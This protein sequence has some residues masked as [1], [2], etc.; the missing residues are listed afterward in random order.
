MKKFIVNTLAVGLAGL[1]LSPLVN[2]ASITDTSSDLAKVGYSFG[3]MMGEGNKDTVNDLD[4][5][6][7]YQGFKDSY[8]NKQPTLTAEQMQK[9]LVAYGKRREAEY[10]KQ[11]QAL[12]RKNLEQ[13][14]VF[15]AKNAKKAGVI[16]TKSGLQYEVL[17]QGTGKMPTAND[18]V[19]VNYEGHL[20]DGTI[21]DSSIKRGEPV[22]FPLKQVIKGWREGLPLMREGAKYRFFVPAKLGYGEA[23]MPGIEPNSVLIFDINLLEVNPKPVKSEQAPSTN[24]SK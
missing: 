22:Q 13:G 9:T 1:M 6:A 18:T 11:I 21:F 19:K 17:A 12:A 24:Q 20:I 5:D 14:E 15:L 7:F 16:T 23:G 2:A 3:Y 10:A 8:G 4:L